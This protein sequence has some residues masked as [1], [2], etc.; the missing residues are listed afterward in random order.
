MGCYFRSTHKHTHTRAPNCSF[1]FRLNRKAK[2]NL[3]NDLRDKGAAF[4]IDEHNAE[5]KNNTPSIHFKAGVA[6]IDAK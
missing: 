1:G 5:L 6:K 4:A 2:Y 3:E